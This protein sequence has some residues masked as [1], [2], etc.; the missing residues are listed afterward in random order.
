L[1]VPTR[2]PAAL[3]AAL[4]SVLADETF[5]Q[6]LGMAAADRARARYG[7]DRIAFETASVYQQVLEGRQ[8]AVSLAVAR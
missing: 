6:G 5:L 7:W 1:L 3:A 2:R 8:A 4:R